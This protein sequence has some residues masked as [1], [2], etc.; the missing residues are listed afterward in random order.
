MTN[1]TDLEKTFMIGLFLANRDVRMNFAK[2]WEEQNPETLDLLNP[3]DEL[4]GNSVLYRFAPD[5]ANLAGIPM[6]RARGVM[7]SLIKK[8][9]FTFM[10][11][12][13]YGYKYD[14]LAVDENGFD[15]L[16]GFFAK[17]FA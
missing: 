11:K 17:F 2:S 16:K 4:K 5:V 13:E 7:S 15:K 10:P 14:V 8:G 9:V 6:T 3:D 1:F 12:G